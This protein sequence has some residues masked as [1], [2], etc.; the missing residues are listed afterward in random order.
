[1]IKATGVPGLKVID[2]TNIQVIVGTEVQFVADEMNKI[3]GNPVAAPV[4]SAPVA[5][6]T[7]VV[8]GPQTHAIFAVATGKVIPISQVADDVFSQKMMGDGFAVIPE[9][10]AIFAPIT[11]TIASVFPTKHA[12]GITTASGVEVLLH[13]G[14][15]TVQLNGEPFSLYVEAGQKVARGQLIAKVDLVALEAAGKKSDMI[16]VFT[17]PEQVESLT[18]NTG[19]EEANEVIGSVTTK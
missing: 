7:E 13:M 5:E 1:K 9:T 3:H 11:G 15:D 2:K 4:T 18:I 14:L 16:V 17:N 10:G 19:V 12:L 8:E 6:V